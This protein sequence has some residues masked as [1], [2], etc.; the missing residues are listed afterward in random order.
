MS[1]GQT[2]RRLLLRLVRALGMAA[3]VP[4][5]IVP[6]LPTAARDLAPTR[7]A[8]ACGGSTAART[9][10]NAGQTLARAPLTVAPERVTRGQPA[11][12]AFEN[13]TGWAYSPRWRKPRADVV[14]DMRRMR[15]LGCNTVY[16]GHNSAGNTDPD[17]YEPGLAPANW[18]AIAAATPNADNARTVV[19]A[20]TTAVD[21]ARE[22]GLDVVLGIGYQIMMGDEWNANHPGDLR[23]NRNGEL[24][25][26]WG[27]VFTASPYAPA[28]QRD[29]REYYAWVNQTFVLPNPHVVALNLADEPMGSD[30]SVHAM[31]AFQARYGLPF[32][33]A[34]ST[35]RGEFLSGVIADYAAWS[36]TYWELLNPQVRT[37]M[38]FHVQRD[39][40]FLP[41]IERIFAQTP[42]S[43]I[44]SEDTHL[45]DGLID[46]TITPQ[47]VRLLYGMCRTFGW[48]SQVYNKPLMLWTG[49][50][51]WGLKQ[52]GGMPEARQ[53]I[54]IVHDATRQAGGRLG[55]LMAWGWNIQFQGVYDDEGNFAADKEGMISGVSQLLAA[56]R[57]RL[58]TPT[59]GRPDRVYHVPAAT[60]L[61]AIGEQRADHLAEGIVELSRIPFE[62][63]NAVYLTDGRALDE[64]R[65]LG[66]P[67]TPL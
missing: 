66:I 39:V 64:A 60:L 8:C 17:A 29:I 38:T 49:A 25:K 20:I 34:A 42:P 55:M 59:G 23:L 53:N 45:D 63:E 22:A 50:N 27:S 36:A 48:L 18:Y 44:F 5:A 35:Q 1:A 33:R 19:G 41:D 47:N 43:F 65:R 56:R 11:P 62:T 9:N 67:I 14:A 57:E 58:S 40:P 32:E 15:D 6:A 24:L 2:R 10:T 3:V 21:A 28:Y 7:Q 4:P 61:P 46:R 26:H 31:A 52:G 16:I 30:F 12:R 51:A 54:E 37:M 13:R